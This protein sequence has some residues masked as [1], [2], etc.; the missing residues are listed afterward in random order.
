MKRREITATGKINNNGQLVMYLGEVNEFFRGWKG[1]RVIARFI[2]APSSSSEALKGYYYNCVVPTMRQALWDSG[3]RRTEEQTEEYLRRLS[4][5]MYEEFEEGGK[6]NNRLRD[7]K[8]LSNAELI[9]HID[10]IKQI[11]AEEF[12]VY[13]EDPTTL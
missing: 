4:P 7:I 1:S 8:E 10:T 3:D 5:I 2:I 13:I 9:E 12:S 11:A 6:Y